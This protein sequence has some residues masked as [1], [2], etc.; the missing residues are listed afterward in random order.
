MRRKRKTD[1][2]LEKQLGGFVRPG[3]V[4]GQSR[5][6]L[7]IRPKPKPEPEPQPPP[8]V[9]PDSSTKKEKG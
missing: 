1:R 3:V 5:R 7:A 4:V 2:E 6:T 9:E 8:V